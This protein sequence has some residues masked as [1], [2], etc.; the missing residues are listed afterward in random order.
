MTD[1]HAEARVVDKPSPEEGEDRRIRRILRARR[2]MM[3]VHRF[4]VCDIFFWRYVSPLF[5]V[6]YEP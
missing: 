5:I 3:S 6:T 4:L 2:L 1:K